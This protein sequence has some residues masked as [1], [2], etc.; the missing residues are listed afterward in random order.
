MSLEVM[1]E[2]KLTRCKIFRVKSTLSSRTTSHSWKTNLHVIGAVITLLHKN[3][4]GLVKARENVGQ[5]RTD[6]GLQF[7][8]GNNVARKDP[9]SRIPWE[10]IAPVVDGVAW[11]VGVAYIHAERGT[12]HLPVDDRPECARTGDSDMPSGLDSETIWLFLEQTRVRVVD[13]H[14]GT[15]DGGVVHSLTFFSLGLTHGYALRVQVP[16]AH[17]PVKVE[18]D[19]LR[20]VAGVLLK[21]KQA[22]NLCFDKKL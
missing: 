12:R 11:V 1:N 21:R 15:I 19:S 16:P 10:I 20:M 7:L 13:W 8:W 9:Y 6:F 3:H 4:L 14:L 18:V 17:V 22:H 5:P 2:M